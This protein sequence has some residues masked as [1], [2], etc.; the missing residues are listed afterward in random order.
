MMRDRLARPLASLRV[1]VT[2]RCNLRCRY[3]MP[4]QD[5]VWLPK[6]SILTFEEI[7][8][9]VGVFTSLGARK[10]RL[11]GGEPLL[12]HDLPALV[13]M[14]SRLD[15]A[16]LAMT[17]NGLLLS[18]WAEPLRRAGLRRVTVS[19]D[20][21]RP[22]RMRDLA[23]SDRHADVVAG[24]AAARATGFERVKLNTVVIRGVN[25]DELVDL[26]E[27]ARR[28]SAE[29]RF[30]EYM[31]VGGATE[32]SMEQ[33]VSQREML[34]VL[35]RRYGAIT[36]VVRGGGDDP[37][38]PAER[39]RLPDGTTFGI[40]ASTTAPF[41]RSCDRSRLTAD[42]TWFLCLYAERG[43]DLREPLRSGATDQELADLITQAWAARTDRGAEERLALAQRGALYQIDALRADPRREMHTRG[44]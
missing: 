10:I 18:R 41:C 8:R 7:A 13:T 31:D 25:D 6:E 32:W 33:V 42:G 3:C 40:I 37:A 22:E 15:L 1:S 29:V 5:Y 34:D 43:V 24:I 9:L 2:D 28:E 38:A 14:L 12:R 23:R 27:F 36:P 30:I 21:L 26:I 19:L 4:E 17:T 20:T 44:G 39:F 16:D 11:T 35:S